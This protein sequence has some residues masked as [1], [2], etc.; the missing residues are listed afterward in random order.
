MPNVRWVIHVPPWGTEELAEFILPELPFSG[1][2][3]RKQE[4]TYQVIEEE[5][6]TLFRCFLQGM[7]E[8]AGA[9]MTAYGR[10]ISVGCLL[11]RDVLDG[12][13]RR[14]RPVEYRLEDGLLSLS[15]PELAAVGLIA[16][17]WGE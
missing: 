13:R 12:S 16:V 7:E 3:L 1:I 6:V 17:H 4:T 11:G 15:V 10:N 8:P 9:D 14:R 2:Y 5:F